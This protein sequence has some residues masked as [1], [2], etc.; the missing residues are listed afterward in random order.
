MSEMTPPAPTGLLSLNPIT[1]L[2]V[3]GSD[4]L[5]FLN[6]QMTNDVRSVEGGGCLYTAVLNAKGQLDAVCHVH[7]LGDFF[8]VEAAAELRESL[9]ARLDRY[10][11]ADDVVLTDDSL[12][13]LRAHLRQRLSGGFDIGNGVG[14]LGV[15]GKLH[16]STVRISIT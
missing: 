8:L 13:D 3:E 14:H 6:G 5:R 16:G 10:L 2:R 11:I 9:L 12:G 15:S 1:F 7:G 4:R